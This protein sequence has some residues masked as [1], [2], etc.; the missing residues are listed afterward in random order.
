MRV[1]LTFRKNWK[2]FAKRSR[3]AQSPT[4]PII[5][6]GYLT[7]ASLRPLRNSPGSCRRTKKRGQAI[8]TSPKTSGTRAFILNK[9]NRHAQSP[10][11][12]T[13]QQSDRAH[14]DSN[15]A[16][17]YNWTVESTMK[18]KGIIHSKYKVRG[19]RGKLKERRSHAA[20]ARSD[21][22]HYVSC[23]ILQ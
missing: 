15:I 18:S 5:S 11:T 1:V 13:N 4:A 9:G 6:T 16:P 8:R 2:P 17:A 12:C 23:N 3:N 14:R 21:R 22:I 10:P 19:I 20:E 7:S